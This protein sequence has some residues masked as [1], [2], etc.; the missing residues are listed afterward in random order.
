[1]S[2]SSGTGVPIYFICYKA[3]RN[4]RYDSSR[5]YS[6]AN[7]SY[8]PGH[9][10]IVRTGRTRG[11][12]P[13]TQHARTLPERHEYRCECGHTGWTRHSDVLRFPLEE[14]K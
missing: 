12:P 6:R 9:E 11:I 5:P 2:R 1:M 3:R 7:Y 8:P 14:S 4:Q 10:E 13:G